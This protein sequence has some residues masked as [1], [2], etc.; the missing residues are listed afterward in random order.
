MTNILCTDIDRM[1]K[2]LRWQVPLSETA[3][4]MGCEGIRSAW[5]Q[6]R[7]SATRTSAAGMER[8]EELN[9]WDPHPC[10]QVEAVNRKDI[11]R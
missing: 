7:F 11:T 8:V 10:L 2:K 5:E 1:E 3:V 4:R 6:R 9:S